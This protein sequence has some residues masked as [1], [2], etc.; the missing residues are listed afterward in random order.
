[1]A[2][3]K[4]IWRSR[5]VK[6]RSRKTIKL[7]ACLGPGDGL[8]FR[9][10][11]GETPRPDRKLAGNR[12][13]KVQPEKRF[14]ATRATLGRSVRRPTS[15]DTKWKGS[16]GSGESGPSRRETG[17][18]RPGRKRT[19][20]RKWKVR[21]E[22]DGKP[23]ADGQVSSR[24]ETASG[25]AR[26]EEAGKLV[27]EDH[28]RKSTGNRRHEGPVGRSSGDPSGSSL[29]Q[30]TTADLRVCVATRKRGAA[31]F[32]PHRDFRIAPRPSGRTSTAS[33]DGDSQ[34]SWVPGLTPLG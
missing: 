8:L 27:T 6:K 22:T 2:V 4:R 1:M 34:G 21:P 28:P 24:R 17:G 14:A 29:G 12:R 30:K 11:E 18:G 5:K 9:H 20:N 26:L 7:S 15:T 19:G 3:V 31:V 32:G 23:N 16:P 10:V 25:K 33:A 13:R